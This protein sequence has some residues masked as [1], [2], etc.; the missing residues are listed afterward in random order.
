[1]TTEPSEKA[2]KRRRTSKPTAGAGEP[3]TIRYGLADLPSTQHRAGLAGLVM[4]V[5][6]LARA[7]GEKK[8]L[9]EIAD[10]DERSVTLRIDHDGLARLFDEL[11][12]AT[13]E[14]T[15]ESALRKDKDKNVVEPRRTEERTE[16]DEKTKKEKSKTVYIY[17]VTVPRARML[18]EYEPERDNQGLWVKLWRNMVWTIL[19]GKPAT[20]A[21]FEARK[22]KLP[23]GDADDAWEKLSDPT[24]P[25]TRLPSTY[26]LGAMAETAEC[27]EF[28]DRARQQFL[29]H[30]WPYVAQIYVPQTLDM[31]KGTY[32][33]D[34]LAIAIPDVAF[35]KT[36]T[37]DYAQTLHKRTNERD[38][39]RPKMAVVDLAVEAGLDLATRLAAVVAAHEGRKATG[40]LVF[41][42]DVVHLGRERNNVR[43]Y[44]NTRVTPDATLLGEYQ[45]VRGRFW[46]PMFRRQIL[47]NVVTSRQWFTGFDRLIETAPHK[48]Q[49]VGRWQF[50][51]DAIEMF[52]ERREHMERSSEE[53]V[54]EKN[55]DVLV[56]DMVKA[57]VYG[58][59]DA[60][61]GTTYKK[62]E[63][64]P[65]LKKSWEEQRQ[66]AAT[67]AFLAVR[68]RTDSDFVGYFAGTLCSK[69]QYL[70]GGRFETIAKALREPTQ[71]SHV[72]TLTLLALSA[73]NW[74][75]SGNNNDKKDKE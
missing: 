13:E 28:Y 27:V 60:K 51:R 72:R 9:C 49:G 50:C 68:S 30:F 23:S 25:V 58:K 59:A 44:S 43:T 5:N 33:F 35:L 14:E 67:E 18:V 45:R 56:Y 7:P 70:A 62:A 40:D 65:A 69:G 8:G 73:H 20:R 63:G 39:Y 48:K 1:M 66:R 22:N 47:L 12:D 17:P 2:P 29:L 3:V 41:G 6:W 32:D 36:F 19:R 24:D 38:R 55:L 11:F 16:R 61:S 34:G 37:E 10:L 71:L 15:D 46:D 64:N 42:Y 53:P 74:S 57:Y 31:H 54:G 21:P 4:M 52:R 75:S 26:Y